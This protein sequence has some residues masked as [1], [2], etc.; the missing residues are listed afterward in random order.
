MA[1]LHE[2]QP[3]RGVEIV[4]QRVS[5]RIIKDLSLSISDVNMGAVA[6]N[7]LR[8]ERLSVS[9][10]GSTFEPKKA[11]LPEDVKGA[12]VSQAT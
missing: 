11:D 6:A 10:G 8:S 1:D 12:L 4:A 7:K 2:Q 3:I 5:T 9:F